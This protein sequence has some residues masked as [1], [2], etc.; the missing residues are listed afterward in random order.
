MLSSFLRTFLFILVA[1][2]ATAQ[3]VVKYPLIEHFTNTIC[4]ACATRNPQLFD[5]VQQY[6][7][8]VH[9]ISYHPPIPYSGCIFYQ[10]NIF[11]NSE[12]TF[13]YSVFGTPLAG[14][15]G[16]LVSGFSEIIP[17]SILTESLNLTSPVEIQVSE[18]GDTE[19]TVQID[20]NIHGEIPEG[21]YLLF[22]A[23]VEK[24]IEYAS[25][26]GE[27][28]HYNVFRDMLTS[29]YGDPFTNITAGENTTIN[30]DYS[31]GEFWI[32]EEIY[33]ISFLQ[34]ADTKEI[35]NSGSKFTSTI[36]STAD[37]SKENILVFPNP[38]QNDIQ[39]ELPEEYSF[40]Q[41]EMKDAQGRIVAAYD[42]ENAGT[43]INIDL[44]SVS[45]GLYYLEIISKEKTF[46][47]KLILH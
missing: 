5:L 9:H 12:R 31:L 44:S 13:W 27:E 41:M 35:L 19:R 43:L 18:S 38:A 47:E 34:N 1:N 26:N 11:E 30:F 28:M 17:E 46:V 40:T 10:E 4:P 14:I 16:E 29:V 20:V 42:L 37:I 15:D 25:P 3:E 24:E 8:A 39:I 7:G 21:N 23:V 33:V 32:E 22:A 6:E 36:T 2:I 45:K